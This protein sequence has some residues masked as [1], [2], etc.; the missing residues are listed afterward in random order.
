M[1]HD[2]LEGIG[3]DIVGVADHE[4]EDVI[5]IWSKLAPA[6]SRS[7]AVTGICSRWW[8]TRECASCI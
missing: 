6:R 3:I 4:A 5:A 2:L 7:L 8:R 1:I